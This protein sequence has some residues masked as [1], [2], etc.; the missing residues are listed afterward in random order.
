[1]YCRDYGTHALCTP[2]HEDAAVWGIGDEPHDIRLQ[3]HFVLHVFRDFALGA[4]VGDFGHRC[5]VVVAE[6]FDAEAPY[7]ARGCVAQA[8]SVAEVL[9]VYAETA[10]AAE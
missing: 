2:A 1:M 3:A 7:T 9:R 8:W 4:G 6:V 5:F 10:P